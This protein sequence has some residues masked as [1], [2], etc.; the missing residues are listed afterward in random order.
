[1][2]SPF[3]IL[4]N[5]GF[6]GVMV[7]TF[8]MTSLLPRLKDLSMVSFSVFYTSKS[9]SDSLQQFAKKNLFHFCN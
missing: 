6:I 4:K 3:I 2:Y 7:L 5:N 9:T 1:M 8:V